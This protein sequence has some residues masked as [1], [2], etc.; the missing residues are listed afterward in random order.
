MEFEVREVYEQSDF[1][2]LNQAVFK[3][4]NKKKPTGR[5]FVTYLLW[6]FV[7]LFALRVIQVTCELFIEMEDNIAF[8][9]PVLGSALFMAVILAGLRLFPGLTTGKTAWKNYRYQGTELLY[10]FWEDRFFE[11]TQIG[12]GYWDYS[13]ALEIVESPTHYFLFVEKNRAYMF[14]KDSFTVGDPADF[15]T[16]ISAK[17]G[18]PIQKIH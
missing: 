9:W 5:K 13:V 2:A 6:A 4:V 7:V 10:Q 14:R 16:F 17:T 12:E 18:L 8:L 3:K 1:K 15:G 11:K